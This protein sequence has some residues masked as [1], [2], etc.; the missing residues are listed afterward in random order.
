MTLPSVRVALASAGS[1]PWMSYVV[2]CLA[3]FT[4]ETDW[5]PTA[6]TGLVLDVESTVPAAQGVSSS[7]SVEVAVLRALVAL[8]GVAVEPRRLAVLAQVR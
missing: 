4:R 7:A 2:G 3:V 1:P 8:S 6:G 5:L